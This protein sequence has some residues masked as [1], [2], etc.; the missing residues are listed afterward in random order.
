MAALDKV[1]ALAEA[2]AGFFW[3][4]QDETGNSAGTYLNDDPRQ[5]AN[6]SVWETAVDFRFYVFN[7]AHAA[8]MKRRAHWFVPSEVPTFAIWWIAAGTLP[9]LEEGVAAS[10]GCAA[11]GR[12][13]MPLDG[14]NCPADLI[15]GGL[16]YCAAAS[17]SA[18][19]QAIVAR[20]CQFSWRS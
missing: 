12:R 17:A 16:V 11:S 5:V 15:W 18:P 20:I 19:H 6:L 14:T 7:S 3:R 9:T 2:S 1:N 8:F 10:K 4:M 13:P